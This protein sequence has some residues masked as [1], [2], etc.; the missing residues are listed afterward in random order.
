MVNTFSFLFQV[1]VAPVTMN[2]IM[3]SVCLEVPVNVME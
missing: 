3:A 2:V 1:S